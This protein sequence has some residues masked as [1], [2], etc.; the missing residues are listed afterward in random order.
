MQSF[1]TEFF[2]NIKIDQP[3]KGYRFSMDSFLLCHEIPHLTNQTILDIG[4]GSGIIPLILKFKNP[5][6]KIFGI[7]I[8]KELVKFAKK[9]IKNNSMEQS[10]RITCKDI[11][12]VYTNDFDKKIDIIVSN[13][14]YKKES[15]GR[16]NPVKQK[17]I[18]R[19]EIKINI[20]D[21]IRCCKRLLS[22]DGKVYIIFPAERILDLITNMDENNIKIST[23]KFV[24]TKKND[25]AKF[26]IV[27]AI[28]N[29][30]HLPVIT[31]PINIFNLPN[32]DISS[33][34]V[35]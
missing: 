16:L 23:I 12:E 26:V 30:T 7:E 8:Q 33:E 6:V 11:K 31:P 1:I 14:P 5:D 24:H 32:L 28:N 3:Q 2:N 27:S 19:H 34:K 35:Y 25:K 20:K 13:P 15:S 22:P 18:A 17:A 9:N 29:G 4:C 21:I 10:I